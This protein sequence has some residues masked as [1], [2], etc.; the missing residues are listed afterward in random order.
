MKRVP[1]TGIVFSDT[2]SEAPPVFVH[3][4]NNLPAIYETVILLTVR[5]RTDHTHPNTSSSRPHVKITFKPSM[6]LH[7]R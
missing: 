7:S 4:L 1:G 5:C 2:V 3:M 6:K